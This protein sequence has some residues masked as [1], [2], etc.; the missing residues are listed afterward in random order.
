MAGARVREERAEI[1]AEVAG[2]T[3][4]E[5]LAWVAR[6]HPDAPAYSDPVADGWSTITYA[7]AR[8]RVLDIAAGFA[9]IGVE[10]GDAVAL[11]MANR[12][13]HVLADLGAVH[14]GATPCSVYATFAP[15]QVGYVAAHVGAKAA[16]LGGPADLA[17]WEPV[18]G[19]LPALRRIVMLGGTPASGPFLS[20]EELLRRGRAFRAARPA[21]MESR[22]RAVTPQSVAT[23]LYTSGTTGDPKGV[24]LTHANLAYQVAVVERMTELPDLASQISYLTYAHAAERVLS[25][26]LPL[27][28]A[29]HVHFCPDLADLGATLA[30]VEPMMFLGVPRIWEKLAARLRAVFAAE[31]SARRERLRAA[32]AAGLAH[33]EG[34]QYG[35]TSSAETEAAYREADRAVLA[36]VRAMLGLGRVHWAATAAAPMPPDVQ[37]FFA[38]L[39]LNVLGLYGM[40]ET[41]GAITANT[42][43]RHRLDTVGRPGPGVEVRI[44]GDGEILTRSPL[45][46]S[47]YLGD[48]AATAALL[49]PDGWLRTGDLGSMDADGFVRVVDRKKELIITSGGENISPATI[50]SLLKEHPLIGQAL[51][52]GDGRPHPVAVLTLDAES[53]PAWARARGIAADSLPGLAAHPEV[54]AE[55][56]AAVGAANARLARVQRV[57]RWRLI[58]A[59]WTVET[60]ELTPSLKLKRRVIHAKYADVIDSMYPGH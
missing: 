37:R 56:A 54:L 47:G 34:A 55:V 31:P 43:S 28:K 50:E 13:E 23:V 44:A 19:R 30:R 45:N 14:A 22:R 26:Y 11:M 1:E 38:G 3:L 39:G 36:D 59:E 41:A 29:A 7:Q 4:C 48:L 16:V 15:E 35:R 21:V 57:K 33:V 25:L 17:R 32:M 51:A 6:A 2:R 18:L 9:A 8:E 10:P 40:T 46:T 52:C 49:D 27:S 24:P 60:G 42:P 12:S 58:P 20:W 5:R 53:A